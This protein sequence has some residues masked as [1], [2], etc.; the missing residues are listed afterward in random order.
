[1]RRDKMIIVAVRQRTDDSVLMRPGGQSRKVLAN[2]KSRH[3]RGDR[4]KFAA[5]FRGRIRLGNR[6]IVSGI[7]LTDMSVEWASLSV[8][9][10]LR[11]A[12]AYFSA[13]S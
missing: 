13:M 8:R 1:M 2:K 5:D 3:S 9:I 12:P 6:D 10:P 11:R 4:L 7:G